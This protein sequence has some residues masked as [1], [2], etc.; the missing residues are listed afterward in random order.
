MMPPPWRMFPGRRRAGELDGDVV[1]GL[2]QAG[3]ARRLAAQARYCARMPFRKPH[4]PRGEIANAASSRF[5]ARV[6]QGDNNMNLSTATNGL[7]VETSTHFKE[8][9]FTGR[10]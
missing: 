6:A 10:K 7:T 4:P 8:P 5:A 1:C 2:G 9:N 3:L